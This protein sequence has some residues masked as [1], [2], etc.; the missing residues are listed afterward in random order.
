MTVRWEIRREGRA[1]GQADD[2]RARWE[3]TPEKFEVYQGKLL[4]VTKANSRSRS[5][6]NEFRP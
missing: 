6:L 5:V 2:F 1:W 4:T 3:L